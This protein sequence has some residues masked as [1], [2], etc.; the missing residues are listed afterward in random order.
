M[1]I[2]TTKSVLI[3]R[4][5]R[6]EEVIRMRKRS[7]RKGVRERGVLIILTSQSLILFHSTIV[8]KDESLRKL[9][10]IYNVN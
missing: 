2:K 1:S 10:I 7:E 4:I 8:L 9:W 6:R 3:K 5:Y